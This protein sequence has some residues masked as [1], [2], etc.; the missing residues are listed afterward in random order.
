MKKI[1]LLQFVIVVLAFVISIIFYSQTPDDVASHWGIDG[2]VNGYMPKLQGLF[3]IPVLLIVLTLVLQIIP[4]IDPLKLNIDK[5]RKHYDN[6]IV[7]LLIFM[8]AIHCQMVLWNIGIKISMNLTLPLGL[9]ALFFYIGIVL[10]HAKRN[11]TVG[12]RTPWTISNDEVWDK[13]HRVGG[14]LFRIIGI[15][16][17][18]GVVFQNYAWLIILVPVVLAVIYLTIYSYMEY[19]KLKK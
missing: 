17:L 8:V 3:F 14:R 9:G 18:L 5:F 4:R 11:W 1:E 12:I 2:E 16:T 10:E 19:K 15:V 7:L 13:T 6:L